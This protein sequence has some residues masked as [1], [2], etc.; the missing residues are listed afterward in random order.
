MA[1]SSQIP[2]NAIAR[3]ALIPPQG[4][5]SQF[6]G[7]EQHQEGQTCPG[8]ACKAGGIV[9]VALVWD[10]TLGNWGCPAPPLGTGNEGGWQQQPRFLMVLDCIPG[11]NGKYFIVPFVSIRNQA[12]R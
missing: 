2:L 10:K 12:G 8:D 7:P 9:I 1:P 4:A 3:R 5:R 6:P 11:I